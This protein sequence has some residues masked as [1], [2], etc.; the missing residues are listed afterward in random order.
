MSTI[1]SNCKFHPNEL[2][3]CNDTR[4][5]KYPLILKQAQEEQKKAEE[6][7]IRDLKSNFSSKLK[8]NAT[9]LIIFRC[10]NNSTATSSCDAEM[11][12]L[13]NDVGCHHRHI[14]YCKSEQFVSYLKQHNILNSTIPR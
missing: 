2:V 14:I 7:Q 4:L 9:S 1:I 12:S 8:E 10:A 6:L 5:P 3:A 13:Q 11:R